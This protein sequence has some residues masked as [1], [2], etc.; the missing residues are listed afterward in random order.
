M[1]TGKIATVAVF[2]NDGYDGNDGF[3]L[4]FPKRLLKGKKAIGKGSIL[5]V[6]TVIIVIIFGFH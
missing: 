5:T 1:S 6:I 3:F 4:L 2:S